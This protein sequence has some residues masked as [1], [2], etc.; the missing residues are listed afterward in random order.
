M[1]RRGAGGDPEE[2]GR[3]KRTNHHRGVCKKGEQIPSW[4]P[5]R[6]H[7]V[8]ASTCVEGESDC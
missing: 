4:L 3:G 2:R 8:D 1:N 5:K 6:E 7:R